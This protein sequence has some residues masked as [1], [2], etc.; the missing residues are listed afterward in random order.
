[1]PQGQVALGKNLLFSPVPAKE[2]SAGFGVDDA[3][4][5]PAKDDDRE[6]ATSAK[7]SGLRINVAPA[8]DIC[9]P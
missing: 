3:A 8:G 6:T 4:G 9:Q 5:F 2:P 1:M 7:S